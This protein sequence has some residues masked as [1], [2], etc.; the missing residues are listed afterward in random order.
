M[1]GNFAIIEELPLLTF[2]Y[3]CCPKIVQKVEKKVLKVWQLL[4][5][6][7]LLRQYMLKWGT[8]LDWW[9]EQLCCLAGTCKKEGLCC[10]CKFFRYYDAVHLKAPSESKTWHHLFIL[11]IL[12]FAAST[13]YMLIKSPKHSWLVL[14][15]RMRQYSVEVL[16]GCQKVKPFRG[17]ETIRLKCL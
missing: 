8:Y 3:Q 10:Q 5:M 11:K 1:H 7:G 15:R 4:E 9:G 6:V 13:R 14:W 16:I 17:L 12:F 2:F